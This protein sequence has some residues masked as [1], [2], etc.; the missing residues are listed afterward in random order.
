M[1]STTN[2]VRT[3]RSSLKAG[4]SWSKPYIRTRSSCPKIAGA[5]FYSMVV[6]L[7]KLKAE[8]KTRGATVWR[9]AEMKMASGE[10]NLSAGRI[11][12]SM[13]EASSRGIRAL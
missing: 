10:S 7:A 2:Q 13:G 5:W 11:A 9:T 12:C 3:L 4:G 8:R 6:A 1:Q